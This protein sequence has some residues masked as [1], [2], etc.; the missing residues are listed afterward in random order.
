LR[1]TTR[2][3]LIGTCTGSPAGPH[4]PSHP[5]FDLMN[6]LTLSAVK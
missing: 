1:L 4:Q 3:N 5:K 2:T 6:R